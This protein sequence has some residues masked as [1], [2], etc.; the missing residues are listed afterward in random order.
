MASGTRWAGSERS[1]R[2]TTR[3]AARWWRC[4]CCSWIRPAGPPGPWD[5]GP[6]AWGLEGGC[7]GVGFARKPPV[8]LK[9]AIAEKPAVVEKPDTAVAGPVPALKPAAPT[10]EPAKE[11]P[12]DPSS[13][14]LLWAGVVI[15]GALALITG[16]R[17]LV[18]S[19]KGAC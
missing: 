14:T 6:A 3:S 11:R 17:A 10:P 18:L 9:P 19:R 4:R 1:A 15:A 7:C 16:I 5:R 2:S 8:F 13:R 12:A